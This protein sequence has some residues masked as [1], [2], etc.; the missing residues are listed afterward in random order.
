MMSLSIAYGIHTYKA[1]T[2]RRES[3]MCSLA[4][5]CVLYVSRRVVD[6]PSCLTLPTVSGRMC[7]LAIE[8]VLLL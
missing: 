7:S 4:I 3:R 5:E 1:S 8:C 2:Q 6:T